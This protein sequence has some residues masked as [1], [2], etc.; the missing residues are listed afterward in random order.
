M[1]SETQAG[2]T[3]RSFA[4]TRNI[5]GLFNVVW[6]VPHKHSTC[7]KRDG[8]KLCSVWVERSKGTMGRHHEPL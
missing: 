5:M 6:F 2:T 8:E 4:F 7:G 1:K 3:V